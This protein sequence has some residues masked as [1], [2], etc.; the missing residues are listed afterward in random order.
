MNEDKHICDKFVVRVDGYIGPLRSGRR[1]L[2]DQAA[3]RGEEVPVGATVEE[4]MTRGYDVDEDWPSHGVVAE[5]PKSPTGYVI[6]WNQAEQV[7]VWALA[8]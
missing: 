1:A 5:D 7:T 2:R 3:D 8:H 6:R 4:L